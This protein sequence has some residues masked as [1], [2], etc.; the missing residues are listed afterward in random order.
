MKKQE[1][2]KHWECIYNNK[3]HSEFSWYQKVPEVSLRYF[4]ALNLPSTAKIIDVGG[5]NS[6][7]V[8]Y[9]LDLGYHDITA[10]DISETALAKAKERLGDRANKVTWI[11]SDITD[12]EP[13]QHYDFWHD[14]AAF[15]FFTNE[16]DIETYVTIANKALCNNGYMLIGGFSEDGPDMCSGIPVIKYSEKTLSEVFDTHFKKLECVTVK[17]Q[18][19]SEKIQNFIFCSYKKRN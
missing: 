15:H 3:K 9:L 6:F 19:P 12:F 4:E 11:V 5:G 2:K 14:R 17:H 13:K 1:R 7:L 16:M 8:D 10:L 18:T